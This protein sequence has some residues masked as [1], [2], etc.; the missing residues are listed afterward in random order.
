M[1]TDTYMRYDREGHRYVLTSDYVREVMNVELSDVL[2][3]SGSVSDTANVEER[4]LDRV[5]AQIYS[6][7]YR[8]SPTTYRIERELALDD[9]YRPHLRDAMAEQLTYLLTSG[10][11][12][13]FSGVNVLTGA[14]L[15][16]VRMRQAEIAP[17]ARDILESRGVVRRALSPYLLPDIT[18]T[19]EEDGY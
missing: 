13:V 17:L 18:P 6:Y 9:G 12:S 16:P 4:F 7:V 14:V 3:T 2:C 19:Y 10:D 15:D 1:L 5:S 11:V 8:N